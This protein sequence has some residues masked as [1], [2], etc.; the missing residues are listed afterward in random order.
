MSRPCIS[1][2][3]VNQNRCPECLCII[4]KQ[5][6]SELVGT[7]SPVS[8]KG[9]HQGWKQTSIYLQVIHFTSHHTTSQLFWAYLYSAGPQHGNLHL[10][11]WPILFCMPTQEPCVSHSQHKK[12]SGEILEKNAGELTG[13][14][15]IGKKEIPGSKRSMYGYIQTYSRLERENV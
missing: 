11:G 3:H 7:L 4:N 15:E 5:L 8:H 13:R 9:L 2:S 10:A 6:V 1:F 14:V 12:K